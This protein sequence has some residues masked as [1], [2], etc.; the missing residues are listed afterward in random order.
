M[1]RL[2]TITF[3]LSISFCLIAYFPLGIFAGYEYKEILERE[4]VLEILNPESHPKTGN[5]WEI[6]F[7]TED[8]GDLVITLEDEETVEDIEFKGLTCGV[9]QKYYPLVVSEGVGVVS[10]YQCEGISTLRYLVHK[11]GNHSVGL[12]I[13]HGQ[14]SE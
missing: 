12:F 13:V 1:R 10:D 9:Y 11:A 3:W 6:Q 2:L 5:I 4:D 7:R 8:T 14:Y